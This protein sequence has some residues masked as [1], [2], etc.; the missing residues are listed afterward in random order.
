[1]KIKHTLQEIWLIW[2]VTWH[3]LG[4]DPPEI[5]M[6]IIKSLPESPDGKFLDWFLLSGFGTRWTSWAM[7]SVISSGPVKCN[8][9]GQDVID[10]SYS[11]CFCNDK[12]R[13]KFLVDTYPKWNK[14]LPKHL[15][16]KKSDPDNQTLFDAYRFTFKC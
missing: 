11:S 6:P 9:C 1:M 14:D 7:P 4:E 13:D 15:R 2:L 16:L 8:G 10:T 3:R 12:C 5:T